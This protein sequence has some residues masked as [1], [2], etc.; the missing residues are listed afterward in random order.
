[1]KTEKTCDYVLGIYSKE[2]AL[3][4]VNSIS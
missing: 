3:K 4:I 1:M 2:G